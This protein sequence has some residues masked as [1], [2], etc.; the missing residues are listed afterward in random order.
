MN[1]PDESLSARLVSLIEFSKSCVDGVLN[2][3]VI[4]DLDEDDAKGLIARL[5]V[6]DSRSML[7]FSCLN[8][9]QIEADFSNI[10][11]D[12][13]I[14]FITASEKFITDITTILSENSSHE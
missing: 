1:L 12:E 11:L 4:G 13:E 7:L 2:A 9:E 5:S 10:N 6:I 8:V 3:M 14:E